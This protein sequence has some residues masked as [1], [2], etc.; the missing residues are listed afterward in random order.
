VIPPVDQMFSI[1][2]HT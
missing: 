1:G 2:T